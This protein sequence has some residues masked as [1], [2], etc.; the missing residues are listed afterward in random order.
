MP[1]ELPFPDRNSR[2]EPSYALAARRR[3]PLI[4]TRRARRGR[5]G[6]LFAPAAD[7]RSGAHTLPESAR[8]SAL[9]PSRLAH[10]LEHTLRVDASRIDTPDAVR[11][12]RLL[13]AGARCAP[14]PGSRS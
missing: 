1:A 11:S 5:P 12:R 10:G 3:S 8:K 13:A 2:Q 14:H 9:L 4:V 6:H 7:G